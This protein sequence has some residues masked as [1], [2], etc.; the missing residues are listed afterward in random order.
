[1]ALVESTVLSATSIENS[2]KMAQVL[3]IRNEIVQAIQRFQSVCLSLEKVVRMN[4]ASHCEIHFIPLALGELSS[5]YQKKDDVEKALG[6]T[7][8]QRGFLEYI[9]NNRANQEDEDS[10]DGGETELPEHRIEDLFEQMHRAF[11]R[12]DAPPPRDP[13]E[14]VQLFMEAKKKQEE[15]VA[16]ENMEMLKRS[17]E[18]RRLRLE[19]SKWEQTIEWVSNNPLKLAVAT[20]VF[21]CVFLAVALS[22]VDS[23]TFDASKDRKQRRERATKNVGGRVPPPKAGDRK[24]PQQHPEMSEND[25]RDFEQMVKDVKAKNAER[26]EQNKNAKH[27][28]INDDGL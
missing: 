25:M 12:E 27:G 4:P 14:L 24:Q 28:T 20:A 23:D 16:R 8:C 7:Q 26:M 10:T 1:M 22:V 6:L 11:D 18:E 5:I 21:L 17:A 15:K 19:N 2:F 13:Q 3:A 9:A